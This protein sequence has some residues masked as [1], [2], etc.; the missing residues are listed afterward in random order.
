[1]SILASCTDLMSLP[2]TPLKLS[3]WIVVYFHTS[4]SYKHQQECIIEYVIIKRETTRFEEKVIWICWLCLSMCLGRGQVTEYC[5]VAGYF[6]RNIFRQNMYNEFFLMA[7]LWT[8]KRIFFFCVCVC[9]C[10]CVNVAGY[11]RLILKDSFQHWVQSPQRGLEL[12]LVVCVWIDSSFLFL[13]FF[14]FKSFWPQI[15]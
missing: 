1:V 6:D 5:N 10:V 8:Y 13:S 9:V 14:M 2:I 3:L 4:N 12:S 15:Q 11:Y 7:I